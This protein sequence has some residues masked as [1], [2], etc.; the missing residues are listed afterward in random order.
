MQ[1]M[2]RIHA[3]MKSKEKTG[4]FDVYYPAAIICCSHKFVCKQFIRM[5]SLYY[6]IC[7]YELVCTRMLLVCIR[8]LI[9]FHSLVYSYITR[10]YSVVF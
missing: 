6:R 4:T 3:K 9:V 10:L 5:K 7:L 8:V 1:G 2:I